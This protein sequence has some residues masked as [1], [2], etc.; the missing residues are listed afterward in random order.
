MRRN[1][2]TA[3]RKRIQQS[4]S[5]LNSGAQRRYP[6]EVRSMIADYSRERIKAGAALTRVGSE[7]GVSHP[8]LLRILE[9]SQAPMRRVRVARPKAARAQS[10][11]T[12]VVRGP[13]GLTIE[14]LDVEGVAA[15]VT[16]LS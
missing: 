6:A 3:R 11:G 4:I 7:I 10:T 9:E 5:A 16:A 1:H 8:T 2:L 14:G 13:G 12:L 15:L